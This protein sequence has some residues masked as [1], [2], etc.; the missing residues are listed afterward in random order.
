MDDLSQFKVKLLQS[1]NQDTF[2][3]L[4]SC[5]EFN[6][7]A[8]E[9]STFVNGQGHALDLSDLRIVGQECVSVVLAIKQSLLVQLLFANEIRFTEFI[10]IPKELQLTKCLDR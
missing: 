9:F 10:E 1:R 3:L 7:I 4:E 2:S 6:F 8:W 5:D